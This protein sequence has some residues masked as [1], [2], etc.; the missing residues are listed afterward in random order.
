VWRLCACRAAWTGN[1]TWDNF[2]VFSWQ[3]SGGDA[4]G[5][6]LAVINYAPT[7]GQCYA[8]VALHDLGQG[9]L[10][11][12]DLLGDER[13]ER[14]ARALSSEGLYLDL[15]AWGTNIFDIRARAS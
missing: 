15:P 1:P 4:E 10:V 12:T 7:R 9:L 5:K 6:L 8:E 3:G 14:E 2:I 11:L 13:H